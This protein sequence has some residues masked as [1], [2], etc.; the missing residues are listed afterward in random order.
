MENGLV[1]TSIL[2]GNRN[3]EARVHSNVRANYL[4][5]PLLVVAFALAGRIDLDVYNEPLAHDPEGN[6]V[7]LADIWPTPEEIRETIAT[8]LKPEMFEERYGSV[9]DGDAQWQALPVPEESSLYDWDAAS[10]YIQDPPF[11][12]G[13]DLDVPALS[14]IEGARVLARLGDS[15]TTD[16]ISP[17]AAIP[18]DEPAGRY[19]HGKGCGALPVQHLRIPKRES[20][21]DDAGHLRERPHPEPPAGGQGGGLHPQAPRG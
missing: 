17:A 6:P 21:G 12:Q 15:V 2:S 16:H 13:M 4:A 3:F 5:S 1:V 20:R 9:F 8:S 18:K 14:D 19:L 7:F 10:T 11:F